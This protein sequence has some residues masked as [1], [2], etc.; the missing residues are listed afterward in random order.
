MVR[1]YKVSE[2]AALAKVTVRA[3]HHYDQIGLLVPSARSEAGYRLYSDED[4]HRLQ[5]IVV[6]RTLGMSLEAIRVMLDAPEYDRR[7]A[8]L[9]QRAELERRIA[10]SR[11]MVRSIDAALSE[12]ETK[13]EIDM[14]TIFEGF[15]PA[16]YEDEAAERWGHTESY[17]ESARRTAGYTEGD[18]ARVKAES[19][20]I[21][22]CAA[23]AMTAGIAAT[24]ADA[25]DLAERHRLWIERWFYPCSTK[26]HS[27]LAAGYLADDR[28]RASI[29]AYGDGLTDFLAAAIEAN[30]RRDD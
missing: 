22:R 28:F 23:E 10:E 3:L 19:D 21:M 25:M 16:Q 17:R 20:D 24:T 6:G 8:L 7:A 14:K 11:A 2:V 26:M 13:Q 27:L 30:Q 12:L 15:D 29:D 18:W 4:L 5:Q 1:T 9:D